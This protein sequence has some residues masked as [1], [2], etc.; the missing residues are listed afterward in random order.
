MQLRSTPHH[1]QNLPLRSVW[2][3]MFMGSLSHG[4]FRGDESELFKGCLPSAESPEVNHEHAR[5]GD[6]RFLTDS[7]TDLNILTKDVGEL[8]KA[9]PPWVPDVE[10]PDGFDKL[11][12]DTF[13]ASPVN[14][15]EALVGP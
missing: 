13:V 14:G 3:E 8:L 6:Y 5:A 10:S 7:S 1:F 11:F 2:N 4:W 9:S 15:A 12:A